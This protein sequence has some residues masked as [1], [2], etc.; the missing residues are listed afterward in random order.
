[1]KQEDI[2]N[3][4]NDDLSEN[5]AEQSELFAKLKM[6]HAV[7]P[8]ENPKQIATVRKTIARLNTEIRKRELAEA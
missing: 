5:L 2:K 4:S 7:S 1:M 8:L 3:L 6:N